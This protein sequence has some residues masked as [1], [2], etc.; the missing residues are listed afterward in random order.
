MPTAPKIAAGQT[1]TPPVAQPPY[2]PEQ[3][4]RAVA[5]GPVQRTPAK[6]TV[7]QRAVP[8]VPPPLINN[9]VAPATLQAK[10]ALNKSHRPP[11]APGHKPPAGP[12]AR[13]ASPLRGPNL[14][15]TGRAPVVQAKYDVLIEPVLPEETQKD[16]VIKDVTITDR[17]AYPDKVEGVFKFGKTNEKGHTMAW[18]VLKLHYE[19]KYKNKTLAQ[20]AADLN[21]EDKKGVTGGAV[22]PTL[23]AVSEAMKKW[24]EHKH[25]QEVLY[26]DSSG[27]NKGRGSFFRGMKDEYL[28]YKNKN[29]EESKEMKV[30][31]QELMVL[32]AVDFQ[33]SDSK[34]V[35]TERMDRAKRKLGRVYGDDFSWVTLDQ[36]S[37]EVGDL[38]SYKERMKNRIK[39]KYK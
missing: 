32:S 13:P 21:S 39:D 17:P 27:E 24:V 26:W 35:K 16:L 28:S 29:D 36:W 18:D 10:P 34:K 5:T 19:N 8:G 33:E 1:R 12:V 7:W 30:L 6:P 31:Y 3:K 9:R 38:R 11:V 14:P 15:A 23:D 25:K 37:G 2:R 4:S 20:V 22:R